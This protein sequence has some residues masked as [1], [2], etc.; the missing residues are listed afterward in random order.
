MS[1]SKPRP[2]YCTGCQFT[3]R[4]MHQLR[5]HRRTF[6]CVSELTKADLNWGPII[7]QP[8]GYRPALQSVGKWPRVHK[9]RV[10][11]TVRDSRKPGGCGYRGDKAWEG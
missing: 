5:D 10:P 6:R 1:T 4:N 11:G 3:F 8:R 2:A 7:P 9:A